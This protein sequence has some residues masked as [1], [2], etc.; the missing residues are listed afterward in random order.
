MPHEPR[1]YVTFGP[2]V[3]GMQLRIGEPVSAPPMP[4]N[5]TNRSAPYTGAQLNALATSHDIPDGPARHAL[6]TWLQQAG[7]LYHA[8]KQ[9]DDATD[10]RLALATDMR[11]VARAASTLADAL[12]R[13]APQ[14]TAQLRA[15]AHAAAMSA[16]QHD[17]RADGPDAVVVADGA[18][19]LTGPQPETYRPIGWDAEWG[20]LAATGLATNA[21]RLADALTAGRAGRPGTPNALRVWVE[22]M[23]GFWAGVLGRPFTFDAHKGQG[24]TAAYTFCRDALVILDPAAPI[25]ELSTAI[26]KTRTAARKRVGARTGRNPP[27]D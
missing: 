27:S 7:E 3:P 24:V 6:A 21:K 22:N 2:G 25:G 1:R 13:L 4:A 11:R 17:L 14:G 8:L 26:R 16:S 18:A 9:S 5:T 12:A 19:L 20:A 10:Q 23:R 15:V